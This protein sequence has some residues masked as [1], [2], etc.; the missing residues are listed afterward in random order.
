MIRGVSLI[1]NP[2][3]MMRNVC[4]T[5]IGLHRGFVLRFCVHIP[6]FYLDLE[7]WR[8][9]RIHITRYSRRE[10]GEFQMYLQAT[11]GTSVSEWVL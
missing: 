8:L 5:F 9:R 2:L 10:L 11:A 7:H 6:D 1:Q 3:F 4:C